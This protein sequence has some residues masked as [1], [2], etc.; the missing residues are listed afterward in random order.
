M[1]RNLH[2]FVAGLLLFFLA[3]APRPLLL[4]SMP[5]NHH[6]S[7]QSFALTKNDV[8]RLSNK[9]LK[10]FN[11]T[12]DSLTNAA[13]VAELTSDTI[14]TDSL[15]NIL[16]RLK[17]SLRQQN[18]TLCRMKNPTY[19]SLRALYNIPVVC[20]AQVYEY[21]KKTKVFASRSE[22][23]QGLF[24]DDKTASALSSNRMLY[25][26]T[27]MI[28]S[29]QGYSILLGTSDTLTGFTADTIAGQIFLSST[30]TYLQ[31]VDLLI[32]SSL[33]LHELR[34]TLDEWYDQKPAGTYKPQIANW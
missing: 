12:I 2:F 21:D 34:A 15:I 31:I 17:T 20:I 3:C 8:A 13:A 32:V 22:I 16:A 27:G 29:E 28:E 23:A 1:S 25:C 5:D 26:I 30:N 10:I 4:Q 9:I 6:F 18:L 24:T 11:I 7:E 19:E 33:P 14:G